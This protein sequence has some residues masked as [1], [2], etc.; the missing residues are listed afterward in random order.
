MCWGLL[1]LLKAL[2]EFHAREIER[3]AKEKGGEFLADA[4]GEQAHLE[5]L[6]ENDP[7]EFYRRVWE[8]KETADDRF[9]RLAALL[10][11]L[12]GE[13]DE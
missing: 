9:G 3:I 11:R 2:Y 8:L 10:A 4:R 5:Q 6:A 7:E 1:L 13:A 12:R